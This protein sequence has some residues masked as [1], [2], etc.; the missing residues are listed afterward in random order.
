M[1]ILELAARSHRRLSETEEK[2]PRLHMAKNNVFCTLDLKGKIMRRLVEDSEG[3]RRQMIDG[4]KIFFD[5]LTWVLCIPDSEREIF[6]VNAEAKTRK[7]AE[8]LVKEYSAKIKKYQES[9]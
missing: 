6:H 9:L 2:T 8:T 5:D 7:K 3:Q 1:K 4:I